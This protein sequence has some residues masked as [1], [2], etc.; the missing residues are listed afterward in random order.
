[1]DR[2]PGLSDA[3]WADYRTAARD[4]ALIQ[5][6]LADREAQIEGGLISSY[7]EYDFTWEPADDRTWPGGLDDLTAAFEQ[8]MQSIV[9]L[10]A[11]GNVPKAPL[12]PLLYQQMRQAQGLAR[13]ANRVL[14]EAARPDQLPTPR[15]IAA[16]AHLAS[17]AALS[18]AAVGGLAEALKTEAEPSRSPRHT[19]EW[20]LV[21]AHADARRDLRRAGEA[22][23]SAKAQIAPP[24]PA[25][26]VMRTTGIAQRPTPGPLP[27]IRR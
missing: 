17:A 12:Q 23:R 24:P 15:G 3:D 20:R 13:A 18:A 19:V 10:D 21:I 22:I 4:D 7:E 2:P 16:L 9:L 26:S 14:D 1:M 11:S 8:A 5:S 6:E 27:R 25:L